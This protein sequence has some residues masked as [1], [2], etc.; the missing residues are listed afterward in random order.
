MAIPSAASF[1]QRILKHQYLPTTSL[2]HKS[3]ASLL[4]EIAH[5][6]SLIS[7]D[8]ARP[9]LRT[10]EE[11]VQSKV[12]MQK[13]RNCSWICK[14]SCQRLLTAASFH[15]SEFSWST[16]MAKGFV[17]TNCKPNTGHCATW[18][19]EHVEHTA[20]YKSCLR[21]IRSTA[22]SWN[23]LIPAV[24]ERNLCYEELLRDCSANER[25]PTDILNL[26]LENY[27]LIHLY[28]IWIPMYVDSPH[29]VSIIDPT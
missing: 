16:V 22:C 19:S 20:G 18:W 23:S 15:W 9:F 27:R 8:A 1:R 28:R 29:R 12:R 7:F 6:R 2:K 5:A 4:G 14:R 24:E 11:L 26:R 21:I 13:R 10:T 25:C 17:G 3:S